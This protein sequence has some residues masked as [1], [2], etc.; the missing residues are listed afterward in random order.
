MS[1][2]FCGMNSVELEI[3]K[4]ERERSRVFGDLEIKK[5]VR[6]YGSERI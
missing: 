2:E 3:W 5:E 6:D 4:E 1:E